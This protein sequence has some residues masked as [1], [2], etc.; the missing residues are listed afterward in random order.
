MLKRLQHLLI[1]SLAGLCKVLSSLGM[2]KNH[3]FYACV[4][5]HGRRD[6]AGVRTLLLKIH[7][8][9]ADLNIGTLRCFHRRNDVNRRHAEYHICIIRSYQRFQRID[10][11][12]CLRRSHVHLPVTCNNLFS[13]HLHPSP[14]LLFTNLFFFKISFIPLPIPAHNRRPSGRSLNRHFIYR[15]LQPHPEALCPP[16]IP[17]KLR[18]L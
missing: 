3:V 17:G 4:G 10:Q 14:Y 18:L 2:S 9:G 8:L 12:H 1:Y 13:C 11:L 15:L 7:I 16:G 6:L 5:Q